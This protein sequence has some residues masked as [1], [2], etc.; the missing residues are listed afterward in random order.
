MAQDTVSVVIP[1]FNVERYLEVCLNSVCD[2]T[3]QNLEIICVIDGATDASAD[4]AEE[5]ALRDRRIVVLKQQ[6]QGVS[7]AR[8][9]GI[10]HATGKYLFFLDPDDWLDPRGIEALVNAQIEQKVDVVSGA[11]TVF[12][13]D[14]STSRPYKKRRTTGLIS[15]RGHYFYKLEIVVWNKL[16]VLDKVRHIKFLPKLIREDEAYYWGVFS[17]IALVYVIPDA[18]IYYRKR[19]S[20]D[21]LTSIMSNVSNIEDQ[22]IVA[23]DAIYQYSTIRAD[24]KSQFLKCAYGFKKQLTNLGVVPK[25]YSSHAREKFKINSWKLIYCQIKLSLLFEKLKNRLPI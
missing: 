13:D 8:N 7:C 3:Y 15:L 12:D 23:I 18:V 10:D 1:I 6:N 20:S 2:Q 9:V 22:Y 11:I 16:Y 17:S 24:L 4:I 14:T 19:K 21:S 25:R 5:F